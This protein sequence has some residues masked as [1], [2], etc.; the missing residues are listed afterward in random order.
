MNNSRRL[1]IYFGHK[2]FHS[3]ASVGKMVDPAAKNMGIQR[4]CPFWQREGFDSTGFFVG[5]ESKPRS[6]TGE[7]WPKMGHFC[8]VAGRPTEVF[9]E[10]NYAESHRL[11]LLETQS[12]QTGTQN[13]SMESL[14]IR[15]S[16]PIRSGSFSIGYGS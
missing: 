10:R 4:F 9:E 2:T 5:L 1:G 7:Q 11:S 13:T 12:Q 8:C 15:K 14:E 16:I 6:E 3:S